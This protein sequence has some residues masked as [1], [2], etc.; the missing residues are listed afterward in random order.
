M[1]NYLLTGFFLTL[2][3]F[4]CSKKQ[5]VDYLNYDILTTAKEICLFYDFPLDTTGVHETAEIVTFYDKSYELKYSYD[6][7]ETNEYNP[8]FY[9]IKIEVENSIEEATRDFNLNK[10][11]LKTT[12][13][14]IGLELEEIDSLILPGDQNYYA[15]RTKDKS[16]N[17]IFL[18]IRKNK[19]VYTL[20]MSGLYS[21]DNSLLNDLILPK[22]EKLETFKI[23]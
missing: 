10:V 9:S 14:T 5:S 12:N 20:I 17:G 2:F 21:S 23:E 1:R 7:L 8:L 4:S 18:I 6:Y 22:I 3:L 13:K 16:P 15:I 11:A 19:V